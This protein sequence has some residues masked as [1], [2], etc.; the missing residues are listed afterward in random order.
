MRGLLCLWLVFFAVSPVA[1]G[2][3]PDQLVCSEREGLIAV[4]DKIVNEQQLLRNSF[5]QT[6]DLREMRK[7]GCSVEHV[8]AIFSAYHDGFHRTQEGFIFPVFEL[9]YRTGEQ[10]Y[11]VD[12]I[13]RTED[14]RMGSEWH[15]KRELVWHFIT[16]R[17]CRAF[18]GFMQVTGKFVPDYV[19]VPRE[20][21][22]KQYSMSE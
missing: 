10:K 3:R 20:C 14:W 2:Q 22:P 5:G 17:S 7:H 8:P 21:L 15:R 12:G 13:F 11:A 6:I 1:A 18:D 9:H 4:L 19:R 16:P